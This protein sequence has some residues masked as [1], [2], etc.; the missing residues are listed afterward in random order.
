MSPSQR[1]GLGGQSGNVFF[2]QQKTQFSA[3]HQG[4]PSFNLLGSQ[5]QHRSLNTSHVNRFQLSS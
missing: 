2:S 4:S 5:P 1:K 3:G